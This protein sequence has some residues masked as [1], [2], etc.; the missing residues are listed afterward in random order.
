M[1]K[2]QHFS[3]THTV[4]IQKLEIFGYRSFKEA[5]WLPGKLNLVVGPNA[6]G[7]SNL[8]QLLELISQTAKGKLVKTLSDE[9][10]MVSL[11]WDNQPGSLGWRLTMDPVNDNRDPTKDVLTFEFEL[12]Q[13][14]GGSAYHIKKD[15]LG[16]LGGDNN[17]TSPILFQRKNNEPYYFSQRENRIAK[18]LPDFG[19]WEVNESLLC[20]IPRLLNPIPHLTK[21]LLA[22][23]GIYQSIPLDKGSVIRRPSTTQYVTDLEPDGSN[24]VSVLHT[25]YSENQEFKEM[26]D[27]GMIG[28][29]GLEYEG[30]R[31][32]PAAAQQIQ[33]ALKW[34]SSSKPHFAQDLSDGTLRFLFLL[35]VLSH[36]EP[37]TLIAIDKPETDLHFRMLPVIAEY[38]RD[39]ADRSQIVFTSHSPEFLDCFS[40][41]ELTVTLCQWK[42]GQT[43]LETLDTED[44]QTWL[45]EDCLG[46]FFTSGELDL[47][48]QTR[49]EPLE[50]AEERFKDLPTEDEVMERVLKACQDQG[51]E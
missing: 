32:P 34:K 5:S 41:Y 8:L 40:T 24:F 10:G 33:L 17:Q 28:G 21:N 22:N 51:N 7:K 39:A 13:T 44:L 25:L 31:F 2:S 42:E 14:R 18:L 12:E 15:T 38:A 49:S 1:K 27:D 6:S 26:I 35:T 9:G 11:L 20:Q 50:D 29:F 48:A 23:Y 46:Q 37:P 43:E 30:L 16:V 47:I 45:K 36:P 19:D 4:A 3:R